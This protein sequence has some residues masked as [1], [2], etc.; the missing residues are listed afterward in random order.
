MVWQAWQQAEGDKPGDDATSA[1]SKAVA[2]SR[3]HVGSCRLA[4]ALGGSYTAS[5]VA[6]IHAS[7]NSCM[8]RPHLQSCD[9]CPVREDE[10]VSASAL[11][12]SGATFSFSRFK[13][14]RCRMQPAESAA[15]SLVQCKVRQVTEVSRRHLTC[16]SQC[17]LIGLP[18]G[19]CA[20]PHPA[21]PSRGMRRPHARHLLSVA[22]TWLVGSLLH[23]V[24]PQPACA[25]GSQAAQCAP[26]R[27]ESPI[28]HQRVL[29]SRRTTCV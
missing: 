11:W 28:A 17:P 24:S 23:T 20:R 10:W 21:S 19:L 4:G 15:E 1:P 5:A 18:G 8:L 29:R 2:G 12:C 16:I 13:N 22:L 26:C 7:C 3:L 25:S 27:R 6:T 14:C 9:Q